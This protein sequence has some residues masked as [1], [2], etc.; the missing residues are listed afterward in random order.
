MVIRPGPK[1]VTWCTNLNYPRSGPRAWRA[2]GALTDQQLAQCLAHHNFVLKLPADWF[3]KAW[4]VSKGGFAM[5]KKCYGQKTKFYLD[6]A[7]L[8]PFEH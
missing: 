7:V 1:L 6:C 5:V 8:E 3:P 4:G 2:G